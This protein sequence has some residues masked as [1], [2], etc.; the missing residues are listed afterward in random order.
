MEVR[1]G[2]GFVQIFPLT[3]KEKRKYFLPSEQTL[4]GLQRQWKINSLNTMFRKICGPESIQYKAC[5]AF[6][7]LQLNY[8]NVAK[9]PAVAGNGL[10]VYKVRSTG[11][12]GGRVTQTNV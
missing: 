7:A 12:R 3:G 9:T 8:P 6:K 10:T 1:E 11:W 4:R 5:C 2:F